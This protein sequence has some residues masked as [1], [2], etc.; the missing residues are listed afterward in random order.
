M[1]GKIA[2][3]K[4]KPHPKNSRAWTELEERMREFARVVFFRER[5]AVLMGSMD[6]KEQTEEKTCG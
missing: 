1:S 3:E 4:L 5:Q 6:I 2:I